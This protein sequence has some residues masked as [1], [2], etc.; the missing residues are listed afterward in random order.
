MNTNSHQ[1][2][3]LFALLF[4]SFLIQANAQEQSPQAAATATPL[5]R[6]GAIADCQ[7]C[8]ADSARRRYKMSEKKLTECVDYMNGL[9]L[10]FVIHLGDFID[11][12]WE[13][14]DVVCPIYDRLK[15][16]KY[17]VLGNH[18]YSVADEKKK[19]VHKRLG[20]PDRYYDFAKKA[21]RF[22]ILDGNDLSF[23][24]YPEGSPPWRRSATY[25]K[26]SG[27]SSPKWNGAVS[28]EQMTWLDETLADATAKGERAFVFCHFPVFP[29]NVHN[30]WNAPQVV[31]VLESHQ[32]FAAYLNGHN[33]S[34]NYAERDGFHYLTLHGMVDTEETSYSVVEVY[35]DR[36]EVRGI[37]RQTSRTLH[38]KSKPADR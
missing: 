8:D 13:S 14:F 20:L 17:H 29:D 33:H 3:W 32:S 23:H 6:F 27:T 25:Y 24:A 18:D 22:V 34:G 1:K 15:T 36:L 12:D 9:E 16:E 21:H 7:Y 2:L 37:G 31:K 19:K 5:I 35:G 30:L 4:I 38:L 26:A 10:D 28:L 11:K